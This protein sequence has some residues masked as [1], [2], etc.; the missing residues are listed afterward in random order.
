MAAVAAMR[1]EP[2]GALDASPR[3]RTR[4]HA[5]D[6]GEPNAGGRL[7]PEYCRATRQYLGDNGVDPDD[8]ERLMA[9]LSP[10]E[11]ETNGDAVNLPQTL[12]TMTRNGGS[13]KD[14]G[15]LPNGDPAPGGAQD[16]ARRP[17][18]FDGYG[19]YRP[20]HR[21]RRFPEAS[22]IKVI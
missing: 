17:W 7:T 20:L 5:W 6:Q 21:P 2:Q 11:S 13:I 22:H 15:T 1:R 18:A 4:A 10:Y 8:V 12:G 3:R 14:Q 16:W 9:L 19:N